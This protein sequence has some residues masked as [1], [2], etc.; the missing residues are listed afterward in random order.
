MIRSKTMNRINVFERSFAAF[1]ESFVRLLSIPRRVLKTNAKVD[2]TI[3]EEFFEEEALSMTI[4]WDE[5]ELTP[6]EIEYLELI[7]K[8]N[9]QAT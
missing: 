1:E 8:T 7:L 4:S 9:S 2:R 3:V 5:E 6:R